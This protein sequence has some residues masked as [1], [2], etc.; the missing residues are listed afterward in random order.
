M[1]PSQRTRP[2]GPRK[3]QQQKTSA[4]HS[5]VKEL[6]RDSSL[7]EPDR[8]RE[9]IEALDRL[10]VYH[11]DAANPETDYLGGQPPAVEPIALAIRNRARALCAKLEAAN[12][13]LYEKIREEIRRGYRPDALLQYVPTVRRVRGTIRLAHGEGYDY[14]DDLLTGVLNFE[15]PGDRPGDKNFHLAPEMVPYQPTPARHIFELIVR[16][17]LTEQDVLI[18]LGSG[19]GHVPLLVSICTAARAIG[20]ELQPTHVNCARQSARSLNLNNVT[21]LQQ[22]ARETDLSAATV[23]YLYTPFI[24]K[25]L[26]AMLASL[27]QEAS[28]RKIRIY[29]FGPCTPIVA[30]EPWLK[31]TAAPKVDQIAIF[32]SRNESPRPIRH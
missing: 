21:F 12:S 23:F 16:T 26:E 30:Q 29:T 1:R 15:T 24:G 22:D 19:L 20:V 5:L 8:L 9:R 4:L 2:V 27:K 3:S 11:L 10:D 28:R 31:S 14:L 17:A 6:E 32:A 7:E 13:V 25:I 18:D